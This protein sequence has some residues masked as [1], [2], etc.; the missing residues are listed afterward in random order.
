MSM[1]CKKNCCICIPCG[2][3]TTYVTLN[4]VYWVGHGVLDDETELALILFSREA[5]FHPWIWS[6]ENSMSVHKLIN[7]LLYSCCVV[8]YD[9][10]KHY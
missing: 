4:F 8:S 2:Y 6:A 1:I 10:K 7:V 9:S 5:L 3:R